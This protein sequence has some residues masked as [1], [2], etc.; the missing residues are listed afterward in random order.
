MDVFQ[1]L[2]LYESWL[3]DLEEQH[4]FAKNYSVLTGSAAN[5]EWARSI[6][7]SENPD[8]EMSDEEFDR[9][10]DEILKQPIKKSLHRRQRKLPNS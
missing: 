5:P 6:M 2:W 10:S 3:T 7:K 8:F 4:E 1:Y 9:V